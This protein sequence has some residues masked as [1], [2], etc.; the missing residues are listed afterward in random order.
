MQRPERVCSSAVAISTAIK[1]V[2]FF[3]HSCNIY[4]FLLT[5]MCA[6]TVEVTY[7]STTGPL[8]R[9]WLFFMA[10][11]L[12]LRK[13]NAIVYGGLVARFCPC[14]TGQTVKADCSPKRAFLDS[15]GPGNRR[16]M[17]P[18]W[19]CLNSSPWSPLEKN[20]AHCV[21]IYSAEILWAPGQ[22][23]SSYLE[24]GCWC[25]MTLSRLCEGE[26]EGVAP[27]MEYIEYA[28]C[29]TDA[30]WVKRARQLWRNRCGEVSCLKLPTKTRFQI[31]FSG[32]YGYTDPNS[33]LHPPSPYCHLPLHERQGAPVDLA[34]NPRSRA[35]SAEDLGARQLWQLQT[36]NSSTH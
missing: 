7:L 14:L 18:L 4:V 30:V 2:L 33:S 6:Q 8:L 20:S 28:L 25:W 11:C 12:S 10:K 27:V 36:W 13:I 31:R 35:G 5:Q 21:E 34:L 22:A 9:V 24:R 1:V 16:I 23:R 32:V 29:K 3:S 26:N 19:L 15:R 17:K